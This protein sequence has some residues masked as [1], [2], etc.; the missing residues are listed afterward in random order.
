MY[1]DHSQPLLP[2]FPNTCLSQLLNPLSPLVAP[3]CL[4]PASG[5]NPEEN[6]CPLSRNHHWPVV[7]QLTMEPCEHLFIHARMLTFR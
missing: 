3:E 5:H 7:P 1:L 6:L 2:D 4:G